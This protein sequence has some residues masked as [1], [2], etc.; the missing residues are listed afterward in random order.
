ME[1][2]IKFASISEVVGDGTP[3]AFPG[4]V[5]ERESEN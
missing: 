4:V 5:G 3:Q 2:E 1:G